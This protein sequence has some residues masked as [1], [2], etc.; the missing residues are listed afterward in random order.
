MRRYTRDELLSASGAGPEDLAELEKQ[1]LIVAL[2]P[3]RLFGKSDE[4]YTE[5]Q[6]AAL[7]WLVEARR[8]AERSR[9]VGIRQGGELGADAAEEAPDTRRD[10]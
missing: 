8:A 9:R 5:G 3:W 7:R 4:Y 10:R 1:R 6:L 2:R